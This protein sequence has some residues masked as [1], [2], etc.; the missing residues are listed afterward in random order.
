MPTVMNLKK[1]DVETPEKREKCIISVIGCGRI[2]LSTACLFAEAGFKVIGVDTDQRIVHS[3]MKGVT[4]FDEPGLDALVKKH[5]RA[6]SLKAT[7]ETREAASASDVIIVDISVHVDQKKKS[8]YSRVERT[9]KE[10]GTGMRSG[11]LVISEGAAGPSITETLV[12]YML[13]NAS[14]LRAGADFGLV[15]SPIRAVSGRV[16]KDIASYPWVVGA[17][18]KRSLGVARLILS[19]VAK[20]GIV[21]VRNLKTA[22][23]V[24]LFENVQR[25]VNV[26]L[27]NEFAGFCEKAGIDFVEAVKAANSL[28]RCRLPFPGIVS[29]RIQSDS[30][31]LV[32]EAQNVNARLHMTGLAR[33]INEETLRHTLRLTRD[34]LRRCGK[35]IR[36]AKISVFGVSRRPNVK[37]AQGSSTRELVNM[38]RKRAVTVRVYDPLF[39]YKELRELGYPAER[40][41]TKTVEGVDCLVVAVGHDAFKRLNLRRV[42]FLVKSP[43]AIVDMGHVIR[44]AKAE[45]AGFVYRGL[46]RGIWTT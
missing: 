18:D 2:G 12:K 42:K 38:L 20:G 9:C 7:N 32:N 17:I 4:P 34:A 11:S 28:P 36:R 23:A 37:D 43:A 6:G 22:E 45:K 29:D 41:L 19:T 33:K 24:G 3:I 44:P 46:G 26:A 16:L 27:A 31:I 21:E 25:D 13:E 35:T 8:D 30:Y 40:T 5:V 1:R 39:T 14:G 10:V 15:Y